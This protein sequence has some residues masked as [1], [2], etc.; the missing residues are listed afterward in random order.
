[1]AFFE[2]CLPRRVDFVTTH[3]YV[4]RDRQ[5]AP[6][7]PESRLFYLSNGVDRERFAPPDPARINALRK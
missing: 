4:N 6:G 5:L 1:M 7:V 2:N 3:T